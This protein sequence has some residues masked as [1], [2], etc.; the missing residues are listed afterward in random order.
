M[1]EKVNTS[2][3][4]RLYDRTSS[5]KPLFHYEVIDL[6]QVLAR[7]EC[8]FYVKEGIVYKQTSSAIEGEWHVIYVEKQKEGEKEKEE[9]NLNNTLKL[10]MRRFNE[11][12][13]I[14]S[15]KRWSSNTTSTFFPESV[16]FTTI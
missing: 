13:T 2:L 7:R 6:H 9:F 3:E 15:C 14:H 11:E 1:D 4:Y 5:Y 16:P 8:D 10:E 12:K